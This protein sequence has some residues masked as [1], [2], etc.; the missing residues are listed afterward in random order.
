MKPG[1]YKHVKTVL[2]VYL[3]I[4]SFG[5]GS[6]SDSSTSTT[7]FSGV[8]MAGP[9]SGASVT[10]KSVSGIVVAG[11]VTTGTDGSYSI[12]IPN[13][14]LSGDLIFEAS[15]GTF[16]DEA[17]ATTGLAMGTL[18]SHA[19]AGSLAPGSNVAIDPS[20]T[21]IQK[22]IAGGKARAAAESV[23]AAAFGYT[24]DSSI[25]PAFAG[26]SSASTTPQR[27]AGLRAAAF[28]QLTKNLGLSADKQFE[29]INAIAADLADGT[30]DGGMAV[31]TKTLPADLGNRF[32]QAL[33]DFQLSASNKSKLT[34]DKIGAPVFNTIALTD[35]YKVEYIPG[36]MPA[37]TGKTTF[38]IRLT[39][40]AGDSAVSGQAIILKPYM[41]MATKSHTTPVETPVDNGDGTY[42]CTVYYVMP[43]AMN[44]ISMGLWELKV[45][46]G[47]ETA[48]FYP[49]VGMPMGNDMLTK[50]SGVNDS[51]MGMA[52][53]EKRTWFL[54]NDGLTAGMGGT[55]SFKLFLATK[56][57][58]MT[59]SF[60]AVTVGSTLKDQANASW[61]VGSIA[62]EVSTDKSTWVT[63]SDL[64]NG[65]WSAAGLT[66]L[67]AATAGKIYVRL[68][69]GNG[70]T[71]ELKTTDGAQIGAANGYQTFNV[72]PGGM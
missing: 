60:P 19:S 6:S 5:C 38:R 15:G 35:T 22:L 54:F 67:T 10:V 29:L 9:A 65:H 50:L 47:T 64:G 33:V 58:G 57:T 11:P 17:T 63:A 8:V 3:S 16:S 68:T 49:A 39:S 31:S 37:A 48:T 13:Q 71:T 42:G 51:I 1:T 23:F 52:G 26:M 69:V 4:I 28:S 61:T 43:T 14:S 18:T 46:I 41:Y 21:I 34:P 72:T 55:Y 70:G 36:T 59:L 62:I 32:S 12:A 27:L 2:V 7:S 44:G 25:K 30:L 66:G 45:A 53:L 24:P 20:T 56:E 40:R